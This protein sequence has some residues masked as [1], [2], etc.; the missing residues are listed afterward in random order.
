MSGYN[1][2]DELNGPVYAY[3]LNGELIRAVEYRN[4]AIY[5]GFYNNPEFKCNVING[6]LDGLCV[7]W[8]PKTKRRIE[9][10]YD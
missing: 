6:K 10:N 3:N 7:E 2:N 8:N 9:S 1:V 5:N 4:G